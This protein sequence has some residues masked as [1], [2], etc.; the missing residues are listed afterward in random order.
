MVDGQVI[1]VRP[2]GLA[3]RSDGFGT[4]LRA[5]FE[6][7]LAERVGFHWLAVVFGLGAVLYFVS[8]REPFLSVLGASS[9]GS[10]MLAVLLYSRGTGWRVF[11][12]F[13]VLL[14]GASAAKIRVDRLVQPEIGA[15]RFVALSGRV[16]DLENRVELRPRI[17]LDQIRS[18]LIEPTQ[19]PGRVRV[20]LPPTY[21]LPS[22][23]ARITLNTRLASIPGA[24]IPGGMIHTVQ[25]SSKGS[26]AAV[27]RSDNGHSRR[28]RHV[29]QS[30][31]WWRG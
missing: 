7:E 23:G 18:E 17:V 3:R 25:P 31:F 27:F 6:A 24:V 22:L 14:A 29:T 19:T 11:T 10:A 26:A 16:I 21:E 2:S 12:L 15:E 1:V 28:S 20:T 13:A 5:T 9:A 30:I 8:P 4:T